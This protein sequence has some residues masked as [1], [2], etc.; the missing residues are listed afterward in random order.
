MIGLLLILWSERCVWFSAEII[1]KE[2]SLTCVIISF[3]PPLILVTNTKR[4][5]INSERIG[6]SVIQANFKLAN[7]WST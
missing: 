6:N 5:S 3:S 4:R 1:A 2:N 7:Y